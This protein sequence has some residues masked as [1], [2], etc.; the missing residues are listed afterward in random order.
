MPYTK[1]TILG[2]TK[3]AFQENSNTHNH[4]LEISYPP[5]CGLEGCF[6]ADAEGEDEGKVSIP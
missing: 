2:S 4:V 3:W 1:F 6:G 5:T